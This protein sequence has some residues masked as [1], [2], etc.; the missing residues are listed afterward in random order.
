MT[1][2]KDIL[3]EFYISLEDEASD[4]LGIISDNPGVDDGE[5]IDSPLGETRLKYVWQYVCDA[6]AFIAERISTQYDVSR[7][8][9]LDH[10]ELWDD[11]GIA[12]AG[13][14]YTK[15]TLFS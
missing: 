7:N 8:E 5:Y 11:K 9:L 13:S 4:Y 3:N 6:A 14:D 15:E 10:L 12:V 1:I 2:S